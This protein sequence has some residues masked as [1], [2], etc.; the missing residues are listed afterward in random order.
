M[1]APSLARQQVFTDIESSAQ[2][3]REFQPA[4]IL[5]LLRTRAY[6]GEE[7]QTLPS[8][9]REEIM[10]RRVER[11]AVLRNESK[12]FEFLLT[13]GALRWRLGS[14]QLMIEQLQH[15]ET[16]G[17]QPNVSLGVIPWRERNTVF[18]GH[19]FHVYDDDVAVIGTAHAVEVVRDPTV[20]EKYARLFAEL[21]SHAV[22][23]ASAAKELRRICGEYARLSRLELL[24]AR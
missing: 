12:R 24:R 3:T 2:L 4:Y 5:S 18:A 23:G 20:V 21:W 16:L 13:E 19:A 6:I 10:R 22:T 17:E 15:I 11:Q 9:Q 14:P 8:D 1:S 7:L